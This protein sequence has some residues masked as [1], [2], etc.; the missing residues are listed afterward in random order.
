MQAPGCPAPFSMWLL[1]IVHSLYASSSGSSF[2]LLPPSRRCPVHQV[3]SMNGTA[4]HA[5]IVVVET[6]EIKQLK[7]KRCHACPLPSV[8]LPIL[9]YNRAF[10]Y[11]TGWGCHTI[12]ARLSSLLTATCRV[13]RYGRSA[14]GAWPAA[15][16][17]ANRMNHSVGGNILLYFIATLERWMKQLMPCNDKACS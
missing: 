4:V 6:Y 2:S 13:D 11:R 16:S 17:D 15:P 14:P 8:I 1:R 5:E 9:G 7:K 10:L 12:I 3:P